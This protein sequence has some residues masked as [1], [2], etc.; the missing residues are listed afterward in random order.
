MNKKNVKSLVS[1]LLM[2]FAM[3][4]MISCQE[5]DLSKNPETGSV[6]LSV[7]A[8]SSGGID[9]QSSVRIAATS[10]I[11]TEAYLGIDE[12]ELESLEEY[13]AEEI[14]ESEGEESDTEQETDNEGSDSEEE[15]EFEWE[16]PFVLNLITGE[17]TPELPTVEVVAGTYKEFEAELIPIIGDSASVVVRGAVIVDTDSIPFELVFEQEL[18]FEIEN[19]DGFEV[20]PNSLSSI[21]VEFNLDSLLAGIDFSLAE[22]DTDGVVRISKDQNTALISAIVSNFESSGDCGKDED[23]DHELD[24]DED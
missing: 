12:I 17:S 13:E 24:D 2:G 1:C 8:I 22:F 10:I 18:E 3:L 20:T 4:M 5:Q 23:G 11:I 19:E 6:N 15:D 21:L 7:K 16:G 14:E 9:S